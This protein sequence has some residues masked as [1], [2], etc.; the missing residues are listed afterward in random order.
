MQQAIFKFQLVDWNQ[1]ALE[2]QAGELI[3]HLKRL[4]LHWPLCG[5]AHCSVFGRKAAPLFSDFKI[6]IPCIIYITAY[7]VMTGLYFNSSFFSQGFCF[8]INLSS[9]SYSLECQGIKTSS[10]QWSP[11]TPRVSSK[12]NWHQFQLYFYFTTGFLNWS[13]CISHGSD[14]L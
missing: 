5:G 3:F 12:L 10:H 2:A 6:I 9:T 11:S 7:N 8:E 1:H 14:N 13:I 4:H